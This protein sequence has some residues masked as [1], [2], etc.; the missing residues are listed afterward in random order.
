MAKGVGRGTGLS[1][2]ESEEPQ[3][4]LVGEAIWPLQGSGNMACVRVGG[5]EEGGN[6]WAWMGSQ[7]QEGQG[8]AVRRDLVGV[9]GRRTGGGD[10]QWGGRALAWVGSRRPQT[11]WPK[12]RRETLPTSSE[13]AC[14]RHQ[15][16]PPTECAQEGPGSRA[17]LDVGSPGSGPVVL[18]S[19]SLSSLCCPGPGGQ[20]S[21]GTAGAATP[22]DAGLAPEITAPPFRR[23]HP[24]QGA[25][26]RGAGAGGVRGC[27][28]RSE[29]Q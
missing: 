3:G 2:V 28:G 12:G 10:S 25:G 24:A 14:G 20:G 1:Q 16:F 19:I 5:T 23:L 11:R 4:Q 27:D 29:A 22:A 17:V 21:T 7:G 13:A 26:S 15:T 18:V 6:V 9:R 8:K